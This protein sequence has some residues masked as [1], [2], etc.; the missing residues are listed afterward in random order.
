M[1]CALSL[2]EVQTMPRDVGKT[3]RECASLLLFNVNVFAS[4][5]FSSILSDL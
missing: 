4:C 3:K 2:I 5:G 1:L